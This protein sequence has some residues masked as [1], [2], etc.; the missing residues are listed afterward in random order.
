MIKLFFLF[1]LCLIPCFGQDLTI[2]QNDFALEQREE[3]GFHLFIRKKTDISSVLLTESTRD[4][5]MSEAN[6][7]YRAL[8]WNP[9]NGDEIRL[10]DGFAIPSESGIF[11]LVSST[12]V[13]HPELGEAFHIFVPW[14]VNYGYEGMRQNEVRMTDGTYI[15]IRTFSLPYADYRGS[16]FDNPF[17]LR[18]IQRAVEA[19][20]DTYSRE[21]VVSFSEITRRGGGEFVFASNPTEM[22]EHIEA[23]LLQEAGNSLDIVICFDTTGSMGRYIDAVRRMLIP[24]LRRH[25]SRFPDFRI[26]LV[27]YRD[28]PPDIYITRIMPFT[29]D[30]FY[31]QRYLSAAVAWGGGDIPEA[32]YEALYDGADKFPWALDSRLMILI[33]D[34]PPH[35]EP[36]GEITAEMAYRRIEEQ[37]ITVSAILLPQ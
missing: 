9:I 4:P 11:S 16:F 34:A 5:S 31:F 37:G 1:F 17:E 32:V 30:F 22:M 36:R 14:V 33:G 3:E 23:L 26:G 10:L 24:M 35:P 28:Y 25:L 6:Y 21:A 20:D 29:R 13:P 18:G 7:A 27:L 19:P 12:P 15:N 8:E 2:D